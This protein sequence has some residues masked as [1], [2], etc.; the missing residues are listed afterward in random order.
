MM[1]NTILVVLSRH[2]PDLKDE[3]DSLTREETNGGTEMPDQGNVKVFRR[4]LRRNKAR[5]Y[6]L[7]Y[8]VHVCQWA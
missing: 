4:I 3:D 5:E 1:L 8:L 6:G 2:L 7:A